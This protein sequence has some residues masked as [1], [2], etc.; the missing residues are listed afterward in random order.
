MQTSHAAIV[1][2]G[3]VSNKPI[4]LKLLPFVQRQYFDRTEDR[5]IFD[6]IEKFIVTYSALPSKEAIL[7]DVE[8][9]RDIAEEYEEDVFN[10]LEEIW[11]TNVSSSSEWLD[12]TIKEFVRD[13]A[14]RLAVLESASIVSGETDKPK[15]MVASLITEALAINFDESVGEDLEN[16]EKR[17][18]RYSDTADHIPFNIK[19]LNILTKGGVVRKSINI[20]LA[21]TNVGKSF[22]MCSMAA[23]N[24]L[25][26]YNVLYITGELSQDQ[27]SMRIEG[28]ILDIVCNDIPDLDPEFYANKMREVFSR[29]PGRMIVKEYPMGTTTILSFYT[30]LDELK[31]KEGFVPD[32]IYV[33]YLGVF[34][35]A[36]T[37]SKSGMYE[38]GKYVTEDLRALAQSRNVAI[39]TAGQLNRSGFTSTDPDLADTAESFGIVMPADLVVILYTTEELM[40]E[41]RMVGLLRKTRY[42]RKNVLNKFLLGTDYDKMRLYDVQDYDKYIPKAK[43]EPKNS[44]KAIA[45]NVKSAKNR[46]RDLTRR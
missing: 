40:E 18:E 32:I 8:N 37:G 1:L 15:A 22:A 42:N 39:I 35:S 28:N 25:T 29:S 23:H 9:R 27:I 14:L 16:F 19:A 30:L 11:D 38:S 7:L 3:L 20:L 24:F 44:E 45:C 13:R 10:R 6:A 43:A 46:L 4:S 41:N 36:R 2:K 21:G 31:S 17:F 33:D 5:Y 26:G 34:L 12:D